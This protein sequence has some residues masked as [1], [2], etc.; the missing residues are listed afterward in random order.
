MRRVFV[1]ANHYIAIL[2]PFD[3]LHDRAMAVSSSLE[4]A[5]YITTDAVLLE[6]LAFVAARGSS[7]RQSAVAMIE[8]LKASPITEIIPVSGELFD[9]GLELYRQRPDKGYS[10]ADCIAMDVCRSEGIDEILSHDAHFRQE[11]FRTLL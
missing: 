5:T 11:G 8:R 4:D 3:D 1:D 2:L 9:R 10:L 7:A 6:V